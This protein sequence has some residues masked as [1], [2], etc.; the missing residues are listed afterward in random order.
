MSR[1]S[2]ASAILFGRRAPQWLLLTVLLGLCLGLA[3]SGP[4]P[5]Y[6]NTYTVTTTSDGNVGGT[7]R[8][9]VAAASSSQGSNVIAFAPGVTGVIQLTAQLPAIKGNVSIQGPGAR[10]LTV[11]QYP[12]AHDFSG[13]SSVFNVTRDASANISGLT[14]DGGY[15]GGYDG[16]TNKTSTK[17]V[18]NRGALVISDCALF[19]ARTGDNGGGIYNEGQ[20]T[21]S[22]CAIAFNQAYRNGGGI[23]N[24]GVLLLSNSTL[25]ANAAGSDGNLGVGGGLY[26]T[27]TATIKFCT[28]SENSGTS[29]IT[30][31]GHDSGDWNRV[32]NLGG[33]G[34][35]GN[36]G[37]GETFVRAPGDGIFSS[38]GEVDLV[39][40]I[41]YSSRTNVT[42]FGSSNSAIHTSDGHNI[43]S[44]DTG[45]NRSD[46]TGPHRGFDRRSTDPG[47]DPAGLQYNG[48]LTPTIALLYNS[49][50]ID[51]GNP[52]FASATDQRGA[53]RPFGNGVDIGAVEFQPILHIIITGISTSRATAGVVNVTLIVQNTGNMPLTN[54]QV[55]SAR[56]L[57]PGQNASTA[58]KPGSVPDPFDL[59]PNAIRGM[60]LLFNNGSRDI[61]GRAL[62]FLFNGSYTG[63]TFS[64][65]TTVIVPPI[66]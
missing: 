32:Y 31:Y 63:G 10:F 17:C 2:R 50:A 47:L 19:N 18:I 34:G 12:N 60:T 48:G 33:N 25:Y 35:G 4:V 62:P 44:D 61:P 28:I 7:L 54:I 57:L 23:W 20:L 55:T 24:N 58:L 56:L 52:A 49:P 53:P 46:A 3:Y 51:T 11:R 14:I 22:R 27:G 59:A 43:S 8:G 1:H 21:V 15:N 40:T 30:I 9:A 41:L 37:N 65:G 26:N 5:A 38:G 6:A 29:E 39:S 13:V 66:Y 64:A 36:G 42:N 16:R 45:P